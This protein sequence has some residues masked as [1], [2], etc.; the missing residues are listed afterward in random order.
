MSHVLTA[1]DLEARLRA[2]GISPTRQ[3]LQIAALL[4]A[5]P[6][7]YSAEQLIEALAIVQASVSKA[8]VYNTLGLFAR[9]GLLREVVVDRTKVFYD[10]N[11][12][13]HH[14]FYD[15]TSGELTDI[16]EAGINLGQLPSLPDGASVEAVDVVVRVRRRVSST[17]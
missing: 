11:T 17:R 15:V 16:P 2:H 7:H 12:G 4:L 6:C 8:T 3:R 5:A 9:R 10:S 1:T 14:H 13:P